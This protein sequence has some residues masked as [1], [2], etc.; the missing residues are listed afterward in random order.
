LSGGWWTRAKLTARVAGAG[1]RGDEE[2]A[3]GICRGA[4]AA[5]VQD[6]RQSVMES[7]PSGQQGQSSQGIDAMEPSLVVG[8]AAMLAVVIAC[9]GAASSSCAMTTRNTSVLVRRCTAVTIGCQPS[10][11]QYNVQVPR[12][13]LLPRGQCEETSRG[14]ITVSAAADN[15]AARV[16]ERK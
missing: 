10:D 12:S 5:S 9:A 7:T 8:A 4:A 13:G 11:F 2:L 6:T 1:I 15:R 3:S 16:R 14:D